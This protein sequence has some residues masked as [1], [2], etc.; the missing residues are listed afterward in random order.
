M[1]QS[2][3]IDTHVAIWYF[4]EPQLL[5]VAADVAIDSADQ[6]GGTI[7]V[8]AITLVELQYLVEKKRVAPD[9]LRELLLALDDSATSFELQ[10]LDRF[11]ANALASIPRD[12]VSDMPDRI[13][14]ATALHLDLPL[15]TRDGDVR[16]LTNVV[17]VW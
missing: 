5:S 17:T 12:I 16:K 9:A 13:I 3:V 15:V 8:S 7:I 1:S 11:I 10:P 4:L 14:A 2:V 6:P